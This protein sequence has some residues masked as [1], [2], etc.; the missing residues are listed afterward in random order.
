MEE[1]L[2]TGNDRRN[3]RRRWRTDD[4][5]FVWKHLKWTD[6]ELARKFGRTTGAIQAIKVKLRQNRKRHE[7]N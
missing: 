7:T 6:Q 4:I 2:S 5:R 3:H 1:F